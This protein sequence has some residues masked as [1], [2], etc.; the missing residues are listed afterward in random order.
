MLDDD[1]D[2]GELKRLQEFKATRGLTPAP[3]IKCACRILNRH[4]SHKPNC[5][6]AK[7]FGDHVRGFRDKTLAPLM[8][9]SPYYHSSENLAEIREKAAAWADEW[10]L[11]V[12]FEDESFYGESFDGFIGTTLIEFFRKTPLSEGE[13]NKVLRRQKRAARVL[14]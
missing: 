3:S 10:G 13:K 9:S 14:S 1:F 8:T 11:G 6:P 7:P 5:S 12:R 4:G 2:A